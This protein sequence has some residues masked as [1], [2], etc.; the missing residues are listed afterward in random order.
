M[1]KCTKKLKIISFSLSLILLAGCA[2]SIVKSE[3]PDMEVIEQTTVP[4]IRLPSADGTE[5]YDAQDVTLDTSNKNEGYIMARDNGADAAY[6]LRI[7]G[8][9]TA[10]TYD[11]TA[12]DYETFPLQCGSGKYNVRV[13]E[14]VQ[15]DL[16]SP[17]YTLNLNVELEN[18]LL[19]Y[20]YPSQIINYGQDSL[21]VK[22]SYAI[23]DGLSE[24]SGITDRLYH[25]VAENISYD[26]EKAASVQSGYLP[27]PDETLRSGKGI[28]YDFS[29]LLAAMLRS[30]HIPARLVV[31]YVSSLGELHA[32][33]QVYLNGKWVWYDAVMDGSNYKE[34]D[35]SESRR[36]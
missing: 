25:Y 23:S 4:K 29:A 3:W 5:V 11:L 6:K 14:Q 16:Y 28:C 30:H 27:N 2:V 35:Y 21:C 18:D 1:G 15:D 31:G 8:D 22:A 36:Y 9:N 24:N 12:G 10:Y 32:W 13:L 17:I 20:M 19:P 34:S 7:T 33:N 26:D